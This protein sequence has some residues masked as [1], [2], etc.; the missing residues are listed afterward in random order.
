MKC[1]GLR[2]LYLLIKKIIVTKKYNSFSNCNS[3]SQVVANTLVGSVKTKL[4]KRG[5]RH[6]M[7]AKCCKNVKATL[8][9]RSFCGGRFEIVTNSNGYWAHDMLLN[10]FYKIADMRFFD[11]D[12]G[13]ISL[14]PSV[15][16]KKTLEISTD[17]FQV[18]H[19]NGDDIL[20]VA[21]FEIL[22]DRLRFYRSNTIEAK[23]PLI[24]PIEDSSNE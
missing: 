21:T 1:C 6:S 16:S 20:S 5:H 24:V 8:C 15:I 3:G 19:K 18:L 12:L 11:Y 14:A 22:E 7:R 2:N 9:S 13:H 10:T 23:S 17:K 4:T